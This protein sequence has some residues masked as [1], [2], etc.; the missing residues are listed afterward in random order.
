MPSLS[1]K[2]KLKITLIAAAGLLATACTQMESNVE[3]D[4]W[5]PFNRGMYKVNYAIDGLVLKPVTQVYRGVIP[6][7]GQTM[8]HNFVMNLQEPITFG[9]SVLQVDPENSFTSLWRFM[10]N[11][12]IG[13]FG[14]FDVAS[15]VGLRGRTTDFG[16]TLALYG[17]ESGPYLFLPI[18]G[19]SNVRD[20]VGRIGDALMHPATYVDDSGLSI[21]VWSVTAIDTRN[22]Y[23]NTIEDIY[24]TSIDPYATFR[25][26]YLQRRAN[27]I[28]KARTARDAAWKK[29]KAQ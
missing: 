9:N 8:V 16:Q 22:H 2:T 10:L 28:K 7:R 26:G 13:V 17:I 12:T 14:V 27:D 1:A 4:P 23:W 11:S 21:A 18:L 6:E 5:E 25:S 20:G 3:N 29:A 24:T 19:P 15:E